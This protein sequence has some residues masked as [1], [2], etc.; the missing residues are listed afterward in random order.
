MNV[1]DWW[2]GAIGLSIPAAIL[3]TLAM[4][5]V[6]IVAVTVYLHRCSAH[7]AVDLHPAL[8]VFF[9]VWLWLTTG[10]VTKEWTA[11]HRKHHA[12]CETDDDPH[13]PQIS[14]LREILFKGTEYYRAANT[15]ET[16]AKYGKGT[17]DDWLERNVLSRLSTTGV[18][19]M[20]TLDVVLFG[21]VGIVIWAVQMMWIPFFGAGVINGVGHYVGYRNFECPDAARN[22]VPW[23]LVIGGEELHNNHHTYPNSARFS[24]KPWEIDIGWMYIKL[25]AMLG[26]AKPLYTGPVAE[27]VEGKSHIDMDTAWAVVNDRFR[28]MARYAETVVKPLAE[29]ELGRGDAAA[30]R[31]VRRA[32]NVLCRAERIVRD[33]DRRD[34]DAITESSAVL[35]TIYEMRLELTELWNRRNGDELLQGIGKWCAEAEA[36]GIK[37]LRDFVVYLRSYSVPMRAQP[38]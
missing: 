5:H 26:L 31:M 3:F 14:G 7:R 24:T 28:I 15:P 16:L 13:S 19:L 35:K 37:A 29:V 8:R 20:L 2:Y 12:T 10:M 32:R 6:T 33:R 22:I 1:L 9:R 36:T 27:R 38:G 34:I 18:V 11:I 4:T 17:P 25:F 23:G 30:R 21:T